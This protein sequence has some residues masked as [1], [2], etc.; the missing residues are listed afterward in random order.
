MFGLI[1]NAVA[2]LMHGYLTWRIG[3]LH[4]CQPARRRRRLWLS[5]VTLWLLYLAGIQF[6]HDASGGMAGL[7]D[8]LALDWLGALF[9]ATTVMLA[10]DLLTGFGLWAKPYLNHLRTVALT[11]ALLL[12]GVALLQGI[13]E[14][15]VVR[16]E[17]AL[18]GLPAAL[19]NTRLVVLSDLHLGSQLKAKWLAERVAQVEAL[20]PDIIVLLGDIF[21]GHGGV[22][23]ALQPILAHLQ[24]PLGVY[25]VTG[26]HEF[27]GDTEATIAM[28]ET[29]GIIWLRNRWQP[30][31]PGLL[32]AGV[33][34]LTRH[35]RNGDNA[36]R[37]TPLL[38]ARPKGATVL[39]SHSPLQV[40]QAAASGAA[41]MLSGH[42]HGGQ[43]WPFGYLVTHYYPYL[44]GRFQI[45][46]MT[47][48]VSRGTGLWGPRMR[49]W[50]P[51]EIIEVVLRV[52]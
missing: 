3:T 44:A 23:N 30:I 4:C 38:A 22:D 31:T 49:L 50:Q 47:L 45:G 40:A 42:T 52:K 13:R 15:I 24:A 1:L 33:D 46:D 25:A 21:E 36:D 29:A 2:T 32:L 17:V 27:H 48:I 8:R 41:L 37:I 5:S 12:T 34:D 7:L 10:L 9:I 16:H 51:G 35:Q 20:K 26:N 6:G 18:D 11:V 14:P 28:S 19:D 43:I 39:L